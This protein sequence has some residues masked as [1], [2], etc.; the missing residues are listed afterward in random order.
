MTRLKRQASQELLPTRPPKLIRRDPSVLSRL[1]GGIAS[2]SK[3]FSA[4]VN[5]FHEG[6]GLVHSTFSRVMR[7]RCSCT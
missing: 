4:N 7:L 1:A 6:T 2:A 5:T 3:F